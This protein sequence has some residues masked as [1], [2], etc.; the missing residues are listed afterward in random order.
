MYQFLQTLRNAPSIGYRAETSFLK[1]NVQRSATEIK[2]F[3]LSNNRL[4]LPYLCRIF[5]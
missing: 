2:P 5:A 3:N 1:D 4:F